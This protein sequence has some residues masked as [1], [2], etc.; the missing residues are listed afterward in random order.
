MD[1]NELIVTETTTP[2]YLSILLNKSDDIILVHKENKEPKDESSMSISLEK[3]KSESSLLD[4]TGSPLKV[5]LNDSSLLGTS[6]LELNSNSWSK[7]EETH[8]PMSRQYASQFTSDYIRKNRNKDTKPRTIWCVCDSE[9]ENKTVLMSAVQTTDYI[10]RS[11]VTVGGCVPKNHPSI[12]FEAL[13]NRHL[14]DVAKFTGEK[15]KIPLRQL[16][17]NILSTYEIFGSKITS[18]KFDTSST[19][20]GNVNL[21]VSWNL[22]CAKIPLDNAKCTMIVQT[23]IGQH[24]SSLYCFWKELILLELYIKALSE[25]NSETLHTND[26]LPSSSV[27]SDDAKLIDSVID[28]IANSCQPRYENRGEGV[29]LQQI[30]GCVTEC[31]CYDITDRL[32][33]IL[34]QCTT[35]GALASCLNVI[36]TEVANSET[37]IYVADTNLTSMAHMIRGVK[38]GKM[39]VPLLSGT[40]P[41]EML[42]D[43]GLE[44]LK[45]DFAYI[46]TH[47]NIVSFDE[48][49]ELFINSELYPDSDVKEPET[50]GRKSVMPELKSRKSLMPELKSRKSVM[51]E[52][53]RRQMRA[54]L[55]HKKPVINFENIEKRMKLLGQLYTTL[56]I[57]IL[58][59]NNWLSFAANTVFE[60]FVGAESPLDSFV[61]LAQNKFYE[62]MI[63]LPINEI[64]K[65]IEGYNPNMWRFSLT[66]TRPLYALQSVFHLSQRSIFPP[67]IYK[68]NIAEETMMESNDVYYYYTAMTHI[69]DFIKSKLRCYK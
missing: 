5:S 66:T 49:N 50:K 60:Y 11:V 28:V 34:T 4:I 67:C 19:V 51:P 48:L 26:W 15:Q 63:D 9:D 65:T 40:Q 46:F 14:S 69:T 3:Q 64:Y 21:E 20:K 37:D 38:A 8:F 44:K 12:T 43:I 39:A 59:P 41:I 23:V 54:T 52:M 68:I 33:T 56:E 32:W 55:Y 16:Q 58:V 13:C 35:Y 17:S 24:T 29:N 25:Y 30:L 22:C 6:L 36:F 18:R 2:S 42:I 10:S 27:S 61:T 62:V 47:G 45:K 57:L 7:M 31:N 1:S 53:S